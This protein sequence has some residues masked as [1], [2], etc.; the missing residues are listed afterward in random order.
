MSS[1]LTFAKG[2]INFR[3]NAYGQHQTSP[4]AYLLLSFV[5]HL[6]IR[7]GFRY[8]GCQPRAL[9]QIRRVQLT[10]DERHEGGFRRSRKDLLHG[11]S[12]S[13]HKHCKRD[14]KGVRVSMY[15]FRSGRQRMAIVLVRIFLCAEPR[16]PLSIGRD[17]IRQRRNFVQIATWKT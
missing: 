15:G 9:L 17:V 3:A 1:S 5:K 11:G 16:K 4:L 8:E 10:S 7:H 12:L 14:V 6:S 13:R 2:R